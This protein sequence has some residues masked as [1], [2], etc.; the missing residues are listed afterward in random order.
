MNKAIAAIC[1][2]V[3]LAAAAGPASART[4]HHRQ[5]YPAAAPQSTIHSGWGPPRTWD[6]IEISHPEG[7]G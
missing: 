2:G 5:G 7:G 1:V 6:E 4:K 3:L